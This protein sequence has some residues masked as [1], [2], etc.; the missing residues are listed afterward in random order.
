MTVLLD[1]TVLV[2]GLVESHPE[3]E[4]AFPW[5][6]R[7]RATELSVCVAAHSIVETYAVL[8]TLPLSP[9]VT[10]A[11]AWALIEHSVLA[12]ARPVDL[13]S[14]AVRE[15]VQGLSRRGI[16]GGVVY[17][18]L[19]A[20]CAVRSHVEWIVTLNEQD[21]RRVVRPDGPGIRRP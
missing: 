16:V 2:A 19:I 11:S 4:A 1:T 14:A 9:R 10:P 20:E 17:D 18:A 8:T 3:H 6:A 7:M 5:L 13:P 12:F 15:V 21:F